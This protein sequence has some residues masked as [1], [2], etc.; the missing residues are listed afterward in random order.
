ML[1]AALLRLTNLAAIGDA[2]RYYT[3]AVASMLQS[4]SNFFFVAAE[5]GGSVSLDKPPVGFWIQSLAA[6]LL[7]VSGFAV[8]LPQLI[9]GLVSILLLFY[10]VRRS[11]GDLDGLL[12][13]LALAVMPV[14]IAVERNNTPDALLIL[15]LLLAAWSF[16]KATETGSL[17]SLLL[18]ALLI[19]IG[20]NIKMLQ[21]F[22]PLPAFYALYLFGAEQPWQH[23]LRNLFLTT[24]IL[25]PVALSWALVVDLTPTDQRPY[26]GGSTTNSAL[27][28]IIGYNGLQRLLG[29]AGPVGT[30]PP[31]GPPQGGPPTGITP[32]GAPPPPFAPSTDGPNP[33]GGPNSGGMF[34]TGQAGPLRMF[35]SGLAA[36]VSWL[37]PF[38]LITLVAMALSNPWRHPYTA[39]HHGLI[40][41]GGWLLTCLIF[42]SVATFFHQYYLVMLGPP[43]AALVAMGFV[44]LWRLRQTQ[45]TRAALLLL[46]AITATLAFQLY[47]VGIYQSLSWW[48]ALP[49]VS[50]LLGAAILLLSLRLQKQI[51]PPMAMALL[52]GALFTIPAVW[53]GFTNAYVDTS[54]GLTQAYGGTGFNPG[55]GGVP[56]NRTGPGSAGVNQS[57]L[58]YL[59]AHTQDVTYLLVVPS[60]QVGAGYVL[61]TGRPVL[62]A[63]GF[64]GSD[65]VIDGERLA[66]LVTQ[67][68]VR[69]VLWEQDDGNRNANS[70]IGS[71]LQQSCTMVSDPDLEITTDQAP[72][73]R[74]GGSTTLYQCGD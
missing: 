17:R 3:A 67:G 71:Y 55:M 34:G 27:D 62:Y 6:S 46:G 4:W 10:L 52:I 74:P 29:G 8:V 40:L 47:A 57:L 30:T 36:Q 60:S 15:T 26:V 19:G 51:L 18:G 56:D 65:P 13:A 49:V 70:T 9:A 73:P 7:G 1:L 20:F 41:W 54:S 33:A 68:E 42:F 39:L 16:L 48:V 14:A 43:L 22:L 69:Y 50:G 2:N 28:L 58:A 25:I 66:D 23:K 11:F 44:W 32:P 37:L 72:R 21:A 63:G 35:Q 61:A 64:N 45:P 31:G 24:L 38:A 5:P 12:A 59:Q 53:S